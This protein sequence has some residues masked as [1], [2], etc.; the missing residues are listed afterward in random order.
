MR[1]LVL[2]FSAFLLQAQAF[3]GR[4]LAELRTALDLAIERKAVPG[5]VYWCGLGSQDVHW[6]QGHR[7]LVPALERMTQDTVFDAAS[8]TK[9]PQN[10]G[11][12]S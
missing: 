10:F 2:L 8:L 11:V 9:M 12:L 3:H 6:A 4:G 5:A 7:A 1:V